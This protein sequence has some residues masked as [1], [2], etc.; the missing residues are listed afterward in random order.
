LDENLIL[1]EIRAQNKASFKRF[2][3]HFYKE[4][5]IYAD[6]YL[7]DK[8]TSE[9]VVQDVFLYVWENAEV[10]QI[11]KSLKYY[12]YKMVR[13]R[14]LNYLKALKITDNSNFIELSINLVS[15]YNL[16]ASDSDEKIIIYN[17][18]ML[19]IETLPSKMQQIFRL[20]FL[21]NY[22]YTEIADELE[23]SVNTVKTQL[24]RARK[25]INQSIVLLIIL[26]S[27]L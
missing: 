4:L 5:V 14:C 20:K 11:E 18:V 9:D 23:I 17:Q 3:N 1:N 15:D 2:F 16:D 7:F 12:L 19:I 26:F 25:K 27:L 8:Y 22:K 21:S 10:M 13:N 6:S 24:K